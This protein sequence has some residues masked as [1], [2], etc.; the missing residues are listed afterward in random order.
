M[1]PAG[2]WDNDVNVNVVTGTCNQE[3]RHTVLTAAVWAVASPSA[4]G[5]ARK[6]IFYE[7]AHCHAAP[8]SCHSNIVA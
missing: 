5:S 8:G 1:T 7:P 4:A 6:F 2:T 3:R